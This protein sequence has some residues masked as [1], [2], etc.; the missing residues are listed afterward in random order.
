[1]TA[2]SSSLRT[3]GSGVLSGGCENKPSIGTPLIGLPPAGPAV[4]TG[5]AYCGSVAP[6]RVWPQGAPVVDINV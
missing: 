1:M 5:D 3:V 6:Q 4:R 2:R